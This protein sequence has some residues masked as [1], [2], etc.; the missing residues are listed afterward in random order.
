MLI[1]YLDESRDCKQTLRIQE[2][3]SH[4]LNPER[5]NVKKPWKKQTIS[6]DPETRYMDVA[7]WPLHSSECEGSLYL[8]ATA[9]SDSY[10][11]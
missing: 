4:M 8:I 10:L 3:S 11:R 9:C 7:V 6:F 5:R 1:Y 2:I